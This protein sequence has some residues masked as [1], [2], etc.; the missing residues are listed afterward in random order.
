[1]DRAE[2]AVDEVVEL[3]AKAHALRRAALG[4]AIGE[5]LLDVFPR[6]D[7][8]V[9]GFEHRCPSLRFGRP[10]LVDLVFVDRVAAQ[11]REEVG[12]DT[13][14][15]EL[16]APLMRAERQGGTRPHIRFRSE[17]DEPE[18]ALAAV[19]GCGS[20]FVPVN[21]ELTPLALRQ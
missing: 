19:G 1:M 16:T 17:S 4:A 8:C 7:A 5:P 11:A 14:L 2:E 10:Q 6:E 21:A 15:P 3:H 13:C 18:H 12:R 20:A 9:A